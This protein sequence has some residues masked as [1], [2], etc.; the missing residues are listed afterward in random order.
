MVEV[1]LA[2]SLRGKPGTVLPVT[3]RKLGELEEYFIEQLSPGR[4]LRLFAGQVVRFEGLARGRGA[5]VDARRQRDPDAE[6]PSYNGGSKFPLS[7][8]P[9][10]SGC[11]RSWCRRRSRWHTAATSQVAGMAEDPGMAQ[12]SSPLPGERELL[13]ETFPRGGAPIS[14]L[15]IPF[16]GRLA[17]QT[18]GMLLT[19][20]L[21]RARL[22]PLGFAAND[23][24]I[25]IFMT[26]DL[27]DPLSE[28]KTAF[29]QRRYELALFHFREAQ[30]ANLGRDQAAF[31]S[32]ICLARL[33]RWTEATAEA[34]ALQRKF[35]ASWPFA[36]ALADIQFA[37]GDD[38]G[39]RRTLDEALRRH[40]GNASAANDAA[41][42]LAT[43]PSAA[44][45]DPSRAVR[46]ATFACER[47]GW[48]NASDIDT[49]AAA[50]ASSGDFARALA[51]QDRALPL[52]A[53]DNRI[54]DENQRQM[55]ERR[56][57]YAAGQPWHRR[58][59]H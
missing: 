44:A 50:L 16:E 43:S 33:K 23:Y 49:L 32:V 51:M 9:R 14:C 26:R 13:V 24:G 10:R 42:F 35:P 54:N 4:H 38:A 47:T 48:K 40:P 2:R 1:R 5:Y 41:W 39:A 57:L 55:Q 29:R 34:K 37:A 6:I 28:G 45:R 12:P 59:E 30:A 53:R 11:G 52:A 36:N 3:G 22:R 27:A 8:Y 20:R 31:A 56:R 58:P 18:L 15:R 46:L 19:R 21:E 17:H 25:A 7:T